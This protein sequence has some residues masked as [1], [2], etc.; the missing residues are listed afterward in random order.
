M[1]AIQ[2]RITLC[3]TTVL[4]LLRDYIEQSARVLIFLHE[5]GDHNKK[6]SK[7]E[8]THCHVYLFDLPHQRPDDAVREH[9]GK[10]SGLPKSDYSCKTT[11][12]KMK[13]GITP[14]GA[15]VYGTTKFLKD[16][17]LVKGFEDH[18]VQLYK[19]LAEKHY[20]PKEE[21]DSPL[22]VIQQVRPDLVW[23]RFFEKMVREPP[24]SEMKNW[25]QSDFK[26]WIMAD[27]L[28][29]FK[30]IP[31]TADLNRYAFSLWMLKHIIG[32]A[33]DEESPLRMEDIPLA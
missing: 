15:Y 18:H 19:E 29:R 8:R 28:N 31:R 2:V 26:K 9:I 10:Y 13:K 6:G 16:P 12:G 21:Q 20:A 3:F 5:K 33:P 25:G 7:I 4:E 17:S 30:P 22:V 23:Q 24:D 1:V 32:K 14:E 27:Y 11:C